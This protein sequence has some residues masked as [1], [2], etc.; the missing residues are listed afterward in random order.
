M[1]ARNTTLPHPDADLSPDA[2]ISADDI[3]VNKV[4]HR[5]RRSFLAKNRR[6]I[7]YGKIKP[8]LEQHGIND[9]LLESEEE[10]LMPLSNQEKQNV[11]R[12]LD[13]GPRRDAG[14]S[15]DR[16]SGSSL[17]GDDDYRKGAI[18]ATADSHK[19]KRRRSV[20]RKLRMHK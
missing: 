14:D 1:A 9:I 3:N 20:L 16:T 4:L 6:T 2:S 12:S 11:L 15:L 5:S 13:A 7:S 10:D 18:G 19:G 8:E 17:E